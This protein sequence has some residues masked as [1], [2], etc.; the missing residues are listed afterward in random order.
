MSKPKPIAEKPPIR[1]RAKQLQTASRNP[2]DAHVKQLLSRSEELFKRQGVHKQ[3]SVDVER[4]GR[5]FVLRGRVD[6][7]RTRS[8][9]FSMVPKKDGARWIVDHLR[10]GIDTRS[11]VSS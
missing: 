9:L 1:P 4:L 3:C 6:S 8:Q 7:H 10:V 11:K 2:C 5:W